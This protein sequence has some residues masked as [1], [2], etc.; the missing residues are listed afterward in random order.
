VYVDFD[1]CLLLEKKYVNT[2]LV[3]FLFKC[4][5]EGKKLTLLTHHDKDIHESLRQIRLENVFDRIVHIDRSHP[6]WKYVDNKS[7]IFIDDSYAER[8]EMANEVGIPVFS[9]DMIKHLNECI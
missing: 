2:Q 6:K 8:Q 9:L 4:F 3:A 1:D 7:S 5:N